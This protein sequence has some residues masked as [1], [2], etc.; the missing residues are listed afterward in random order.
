MGRSNPF[1]HNLCVRNF[2]RMEIDVEVPHGFMVLP[3]LSDSLV[4]QLS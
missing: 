1:Q 2:K 3:H 4:F